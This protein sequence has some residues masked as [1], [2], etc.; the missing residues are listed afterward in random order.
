MNASFGIVLESAEGG[1]RRPCAVPTTDLQHDAM[2][3]ELIVGTL[4]FAHLTDSGSDQSSKGLL[5]TARRP[6]RAVANLR[7]IFRKIMA[8]V[9][10]AELL[11]ATHSPRKN[12]ALPHEKLC[13][14]SLPHGS[15]VEL[16]F[17]AARF[18]EPA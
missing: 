15:H 9:F 6:Y 17:G 10:F 11:A 8:D 4:R 12:L 16:M 13:A 3:Y 14:F 1:Q 18:G 5:S 7:N 2:G